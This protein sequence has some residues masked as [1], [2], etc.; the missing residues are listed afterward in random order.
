MKQ[1]G[2]F[3]ALIVGLGAGLAAAGWLLRDRLMPQPMPPQAPSG[4]SAPNDLTEVKGI[5]PVYSE[6]LNEAGISTLDQLIA[7]GASA[8]AAATGVVE[9]AAADWIAQAAALQDAT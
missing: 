6:R 1:R 7:A 2:A 8:A 9:A 5:G 4:T 3:V